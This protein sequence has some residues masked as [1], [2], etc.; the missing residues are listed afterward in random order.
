MQAGGAIRQ[1]NIFMA[2]VQVSHTPCANSKPF[3][4]QE[5]N[6][7][8]M[9]VIL[10]IFLILLLLGA[11]PFSFTA[12]DSVLLFGWLPSTLAFWWALTL[13]DTVFILLV[14]RHFVRTA[15]KEQGEEDA[16]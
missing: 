4:V 10:P 14:C 1:N 12:R 11:I 2:F 7:M 15:K 9:K 8:K 5:A 6:C 3:S 13:I 16:A